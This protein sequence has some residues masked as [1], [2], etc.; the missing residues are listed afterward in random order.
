MRP[1]GA[2][3]H[4]LVAS[5]ECGVL[6][7]LLRLTTGRCENKPR[8][9]LTSAGPGGRGRA[10][11]PV[12]L[13]GN[14]M[15]TVRSWLRP[16][17][18]PNGPGFPSPGHGGSLPVGTAALRPSV[19]ARGGSVTALPVAV[20][21]SPSSN[22]ARCRP[23]CDDSDTAFVACLIRTRTSG[24]AGPRVRP[25]PHRTGL[26]GNPAGSRSGRRFPPARPA[27]CPPPGPSPSPPMHR[28]SGFLT[29]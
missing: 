18:I 8:G 2:R 26:R 20:T 16:F 11:R 4:P 14:S 21:A 15:V 24:P 29:A 5:R 22:P 10:P 9:S 6:G 1:P 28:I 23:S 27:R 13:P 25:A 12:R 7:W 19:S 17:I 3:S